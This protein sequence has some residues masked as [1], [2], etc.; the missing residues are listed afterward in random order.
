MLYVFWDSLDVRSKKAYRIWSGIHRRHLGILS[1]P[2][3]KGAHF[4]VQRV[5][6]D[7]V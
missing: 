7:V 3:T 1:E 6:D 4:Y 5:K 2:Q